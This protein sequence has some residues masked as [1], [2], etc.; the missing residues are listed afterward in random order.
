MVTKTENGNWSDPSVRAWMR[1][2]ACGASFYLGR[3]SSE[4]ASSSVGAEFGF[5]RCVV[6]LA[7]IDGVCIFE[8]VLGYS[9]KVSESY[10]LEYSILIHYF[11][12]FVRWQLQRMYDV[13]SEVVRRPVVAALRCMEREDTLSSREESHNLTRDHLE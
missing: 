10:V 8:K 3:V 11:Y 5:C 2:G 4:C 9:L 13:A 6:G 7:E 12:T 1:V